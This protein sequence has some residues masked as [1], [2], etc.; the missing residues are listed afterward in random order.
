MMWAIIGAV[1]VLTVAPIAI[2]LTVYAIGW[3]IMLLSTPMLLLFY[4][5]GVCVNALE[6]LAERVRRSLAAKIVAR[7]LIPRN[8]GK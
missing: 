6:R 3:I 1:I 4:L 8:P 5:G 7:R 2:I